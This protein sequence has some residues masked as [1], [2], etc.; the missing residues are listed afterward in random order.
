MVSD[1]SQIRSE[2]DT[3]AARLQEQLNAGGFCV[4]L[5][6]GGHRATLATIGALMA[7]VD[8]RLNKVVIQIASVSGGSITN[9]Y[10]AQRCAFE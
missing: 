5:S 3:A 8:R 7:L 1:S 2:V 9:A 4:A 6:G 10:V